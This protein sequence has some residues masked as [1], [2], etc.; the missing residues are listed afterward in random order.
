MDVPETRYTRSGDVHIAYQVVGN[1]GFDIVLIPGY[2]T[3]VEAWWDLS[4]AARFLTRLA[5]FSRLILFDKRGAGLSDRA[6]GIPTLEQRM[7]DVRAVMEATGL[8]RAALLGW[9]EGGPLSLLFSATYPDRTLAL[10]LYATC[11][12]WPT[13]A[14]SPQ[15]T[16]AVFDQ[17]ERNW[18][19]GI[20]LENRNPSVA[21][22]ENLRRQMARFERLSASPAAAI[23]LLRMN[24]EIDVRPI[25]PTIRMPTLVLHRNGDRNIQAAGGS[26][27]TAQIAGA[28]YVELEG[29]DHAPFLGDSDRL[30]DE[31]EKFL[32]G[33]RASI[34]PD[35]V[36]ATVLFTDIVASTKRAAE[37]GDHDWLALLGRH[38][39]VVRQELVRFHGSEL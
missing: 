9:S 17:I 20:G 24:S 3:N 19:T 5:A 14:R 31:I 26:Y 23:D 25:L 2:V 10:V 12:H 38:N 34:E 16:Q 33:S 39:D 11:A 22:D 30:T 27:L 28:K 15:Q 7:D 35:R 32:T 8:E 6:V 4:P 29:I 36:L 37:M 18:G 13:W 1:G 21:L